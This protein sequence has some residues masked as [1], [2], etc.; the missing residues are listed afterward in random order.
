MRR[1]IIIWLVIC[2]LTALAVAGPIK[3]RSINNNVV[4]EFESIDI[5]QAPVARELLSIEQRAHGTLSSSTLP[6]SLDP[7]TIISLQVIVAQEQFEA[8]FFQQLANI[9]ND[10]PGYVI[11]NGN[12]RKLAI[13]SLIAIVAVIGQEGEQQDFF[14]ILGGRIPSELPFL[15]NSVRD[16]AF[17]ALSQNFIVPGS[18]P[19]LAQIDVFNQLHNMEP[20]TVE[21]S[22]DP[23]ISIEEIVE[24][25]FSLP[26]GSQLEN[27]EVAYI[28]QQNVPFVMPYI[29]LSQ[30]GQGLYVKAPFPYV[31][32]LL[33]GL[34]ILAI[35]PTTVSGGLGSNQHVAN[36]TL[37]G[38]GLVIVN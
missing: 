7:D 17:C 30:E 12:A 25:S 9:T 33:N 6:A 36:A 38:P 34:T 8:A 28:N 10:E 37:A 21:C 2:N 1:N 11:D 14:R 32:H 16:F 15:T 5:F 29:L 35:V 3:P 4:D 27:C 13:D 18:C 23:S 24:L 20:L 19:N 22:F 31:E 26:D